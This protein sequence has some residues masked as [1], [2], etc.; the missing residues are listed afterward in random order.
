MIKYICENICSSG[1]KGFCMKNKS[2]IIVLILAL[3]MLFSMIGIFAISSSAASGSITVYFE[4]NW[5]WTD[6]RCYYWTNSSNNGWPG[7]SMNKVGTLN[8][9]D[10]YS[11]EVPAN[12]TGI[13]FNGIKNDG[14]GTRDQSPDIKSGIS[15]CTVWYMNWN[16]GNQVLTRSE[17]WHVYT[18]SVTS[19]PTCSITGVKTYT[20]SACGNSYTENIPKTNHNFVDGVCS[21]GCGTTS[22]TVYAYNYHKWS[23]MYCYCWGVDENGETV[24]DYYKA[25]PGEKMKDLGN[26]LWSYE[27]P[28]DCNRIIFNNGNT[29]AMEQTVDLVCPGEN[30]VYDTKSTTDYW[31]DYVPGKYGLTGNFMNMTWAT[32]YVEPEDGIVTWNIAL[33]NGDFEFKITREGYVWY[34]N[35]SSDPMQDTTEATSNVGWVMDRDADNC[36]FTAKGGS[37]VFT[38]NTTTNSITVHRHVYVNGTC[39]GCSDKIDSALEL[40][41]A[42]N[43]AVFDPESSDTIQL[44]ADMS[45]SNIIESDKYFVKTSAT[46]W[47]AQTHHLYIP[48]GGNVILDLNGH[49]I[50]S[51]AN[52]SCNILLVTNGATLTLTDTAETKGSITANAVGGSVI[53]NFGGVVTLDGGVVVDSKNYTHYSVYTTNVLNSEETSESGQLIVNNAVVHSGFGCLQIVGGSSVTVNKGSFIMDADSNNPSANQQNIVYVA[54]GTNLTING[55]SFTSEVNM[56]GAAVCAESAS[57]VV[58]NDGYFEGPSM[59]VQSRAGS[60]ITLYGGAYANSFSYGGDTGPGAIENCIS[61]STAIVSRSSGIATYARTSISVGTTYYVGENALADAIA[62]AEAGDIITLE[63]DFTLS[64]NLTIDKGIILDLNGHVLSAEDGI[65]LVLEAP[66]VLL[67]GVGSGDITAELDFVGEGTL[68]TAVALNGKIIPTAS[69]A[70]SAAQPGDVITILGAYFL[71]NSDIVEKLLALEGVTVNISDEHAEALKYKGYV[72]E[73]S[74]TVG[75]LDI[76]AKTPYYVGANGNWWFGDSDT[77]VQAVGKNGETITVVLVETESEGLTDTHTITFSD[78]YK[79]TITV[80]HART[81]VEIQQTAVSADGSTITYTIY[82]NDDTASTFNVK[83]GIDGKAPTIAIQDGYWVINGTP[84]GVKAEGENGRSIKSCIKS[85]DGFVDV[86]TITFTDGSTYQFTVTNGISISSI[87]KSSTSADGLVDTYTITYTNGETQT[88][89]VT[90]GKNGIQGVKGDP[91]ADGVPPVIT[92]GANGNWYVNSVDSGVKAQG[93]QGDPGKSISAITKTGTDGLVDTY[94]ITYT[95]GNTATFTVTNGADGE[96]GIQGVQGVPGKDGVVPVITVGENGNWFVDGTDTGVLAQA[97]KGDTGADGSDGE[98]G[99]TPHVGENGNWWIGDFDTGVKVEGADGNRNNK[100]I[101]ISIIVA[102]LLVMIAIV[103][104]FGRTFRFRV[105]F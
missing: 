62:A 99:K 95:S 48:E 39:S 41:G 56:K 23:A 7:K 75:M 45:F 11:L 93:I 37:Y 12:V 55:G 22:T 40:Q 103:T 77:G 102:T 54:A 46:S 31:S 32:E 72:T 60:I 74:S 68:G 18:E 5:K 98:D 29:N 30:K 90:N 28:S 64:D 44:Q 94:T 16:N 15:S 82:Y 97:P 79:V 36:H 59:S 86:Y 2:K 24:V 43:Q 51:A 6:V 65:K 42:I 34:G 52:E 96:Q 17:K 9:N 20:C 50:S 76:L 104:V 26:D 88:F 81:I 57:T 101:V 80:T 100:I 67:D 35:N 70:I 4:N 69:A 105:W 21:Y 73:P 25:W 19:N 47:V 89:T 8:G 63:T 91:G 14:S 78:G 13:I 3:A 53:R 83:V 58:I 92:I 38:F 87:I 49:V 1:Q 33:R 27:I 61:E 84:S 10:L 66:I 71:E 85:S